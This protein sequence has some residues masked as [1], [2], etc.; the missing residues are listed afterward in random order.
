MSRIKVLLLTMCLAIC[1][2]VMAETS[3]FIVRVNTPTSNNKAA[4]VYGS[5]S[6]PQN[7]VNGSIIQFN[8]SYSAV[9][10][11]IKA[12]WKRVTLSD[13]TTQRDSIINEKDGKPDGFD[14]HK[15]EIQSI[16]EGNPLHHLKAR[17]VDN[18]YVKMWV[19]QEQVKE[20]NNTVTKNYLNIDYIGDLK[21][22][23]IT[24]DVYYQGQLMFTIPV[25]GKVGEEYPRIDNIYDPVNNEVSRIPFGM[26]VLNYPTEHVIRATRVAVETE[27]A[28]GA[29]GFYPEGTRYSQITDWYACTMGAAQ[30]VPI[31]E[32]AEY[33][34][35]LGIWVSPEAIPTVK[36]PGEEGFNQE[37]WNAHKAY[38]EN[39]AN[40]PLYFYNH[41]G[42][43]RFSDKMVLEESEYDVLTDM[44]DGYY[45]AM[46]GNP[47]AFR[48]MNKLA[49]PNKYLKWIR[50]SDTDGHFIWDSEGS[51]F[52]IMYN[53]SV[54]PG[55]YSWAGTFNYPDVANN[56]IPP[57]S[58]GCSVILAFESSEDGNF[59]YGLTIDPA[60]K[61]P[62]MVRHRFYNKNG[63]SI[64]PE[65]KEEDTAMSLLPNFRVYMAE[66]SNTSKELEYTV[67]M[68]VP[69]GR[70]P[71]ETMEVIYNEDQYENGRTITF[72]EE[73]LQSDFTA[74]EIEGYEPVVT[75]DNQDR[76]I[77]VTY[78]LAN[79]TASYPDYYYVRNKA[80]WPG[81]FIA[82]DDGGSFTTDPR[83]ASVITFVKA[84]T[85][86]GTANGKVYNAA[87]LFYILEATGGYWTKT[88]LEMDQEKAERFVL[89]DETGNAA[90]DVV[91]GKTYAI[92]TEED[93]LNASNQSL[94]WG[95]NPYDPAGCHLKNCPFTC[96]WEIKRWVNPKKVQ[97][98]IA[99]LNARGEQVAMPSATISWG[100]TT[101][102]HN[103][104]LYSIDE[105]ENYIPGLRIPILN[106]D[107]KTPSIY[108]Y[109][110][111]V[112]AGTLGV[113]YIQS[114]RVTRQ[115]IENKVKSKAFFGIVNQQTHGFFD[116]PDDDHGGF[117]QIAGAYNITGYS[118]AKERYLQ[119]PHIPMG[120]VAWEIDM[121]KYGESEYRFYLRNTSTG[122]YQAKDANSRGYVSTNRMPIVIDLDDDGNMRMEVDYNGTHFAGQDLSAETAPI[123]TMTEGEESKF[124]LISPPSSITKYNLVSDLTQG[125]ITI[126][127]TGE[128]FAAGN[129][130]LSAQPLTNLNAANFIRPK[131]IDGFNVQIVVDNDEA[132]NGA[133][134][135]VT[136][137]YTSDLDVS[138]QKY[139]IRGAKGLEEN[140]KE[141]AHWH[142]WGAEK[143]QYVDAAA[144][145][146]PSVHP[147]ALHNLFFSFEKTT[148]N[149]YR[150]CYDYKAGGKKYY[151]CGNVPRTNSDTPGN[152]Y[153]KEQGEEGFDINQAITVK[154]LHDKNGEYTWFV[155]PYNEGDVAW[156]LTWDNKPGTVW[157]DNKQFNDKS[158][159]IW[160]KAPWNTGVPFEIIPYT[161]KPV[162]VHITGDFYYPKATNSKG[163][164]VEV[165]LVRVGPYGVNSL[166]GDI[167]LKNG[168]QADIHMAI[169]KDDI[170]VR[171]LDGTHYT[172]DIE[173]NDIYV[174]YVNQGLTTQL[175]DIKQ[176]GT[177]Y[178][179]RTTKA[180]HPGDPSYG[181]YTNKNTFE[182]QYNDNRQ[183]YIDH[184]NKK[185]LWQVVEYDGRWYSWNDEEQS[186]IGSSETR[187]NMASFIADDNG[188][189]FEPTNMKSVAPLYTVQFA[190]YPANKTLTLDNSKPR[191]RLVLPNSDAIKAKGQAAAESGTD[192]KG[193]VADKYT[194]PNETYILIDKQVNGEG[195]GEGIHL[196]LPKDMGQTGTTARLQ[197]T[198]DG[199][200][201]QDLSTTDSETLFGATYTITRANYNYTVTFQESLANLKYRARY[202]LNGNK[203]AET[204]PDTYNKTWYFLPSANEWQALKDVYNSVGDEYSKEK[205]DLLND[206]INNYIR[207]ETEINWPDDKTPLFIKNR[208]TGFCM[209]YQ[210]PVDLSRLTKNPETI[211]NSVFY[212]NNSKELAPD[213]EGRHF[214]LYNV[215]G[216]VTD[217]YAYSAYQMGHP[218]WGGSMFG[219]YAATGGAFL[220]P[221]DDIVDFDYDPDAQI[222]AGELYHEHPYSPKMGG[223]MTADG[224]VFTPNKEGHF[225]L[226]S[227]IFEGTGLAEHAQTYGKRVVYSDEEVVDM[228][229]AYWVPVIPAQLDNHYNYE[230]QIVGAPDD[231][232]D[233]VNVKL[234]LTDTEAPHSV[235]DATIGGSFYL[236]SDLAVAGNFVASNIPMDGTTVIT[237]VIT[238]DNVSNPRKVVVTYNLPADYYAKRIKAQAEEARVMLA[239]DESDD[240]YDEDV[241][242]P[243]TY[244]YPSQTAR[245]ALKT[246][247]NQILAKPDADITADEYNN[248]LLPL[249]ERALEDYN[250]TTDVIVPQPGDVITIS[251]VMLCDGE[252]PTLG[253]L[254]RQGAAIETTE[255]A[256]LEEGETP[257]PNKI[258]APVE[259]NYYNW[260]VRQSETDGHVYL[261][262]AWAD[263]FYLTSSGVST[264]PTDWYISSGNF[265]GAL[266]L[267]FSGNTSAYVSTVTSKT[268]MT[269]TAHDWLYGATTTEKTH[270]Y[271]PTSGQGQS[272]DF[273]IMP[274]VSTIDGQKVPRKL[275]TIVVEGPERVKNA[276]IT[277]S[278][279]QHDGLQYLEGGG[280]VVTAR[281]PRTGTTSAELKK[282]VIPQEYADLE[283]TL[284]YDEA[285]QT[286][287]VTYTEKES[288]M[289]ARFL[290]ILQTIETRKY[291]LFDADNDGTNE[292]FDNRYIAAARAIIN[293]EGGATVEEMRQAMITFYRQA[294]KVPFYLINA[295]S[296]KAIETQGGNTLVGKANPDEYDQ[297]MYYKVFFNEIGN[298]DLDPLYY[299]VSVRNGN[300]ISATIAERILSTTNP[301]TSGL[302]NILNR[303]V[304][305]APNTPIPGYGQPGSPLQQ[306]TKVAGYVTLNC[307]NGAD[308]IG[309]WVSSTTANIDITG[310]YDATTDFQKWGMVLARNYRPLPSVY[311][312]YYINED[313][314][315]TSGIKD[316]PAHI[317]YV[318]REG[319]NYVVKCMGDPTNDVTYTWD[320]SLAHQ[321]Y[322]VE[323]KSNEYEKLLKFYRMAKELP[324][325]TDGKVGKYTDKNHLGT[326]LTNAVGALK[327]GTSTDCADKYEEMRQAIAALWLNM[328]KRGFYRIRSAKNGRYLS[329][330]GS[331]SDVA[332]PVATVLDDDKDK[333][334]ESIWYFDYTSYDDVN[335]TATTHLLNY[336][337]GQY[338][339]ACNTVCYPEY[340]TQRDLFTFS[341]QGTSNGGIVSAYAIRSGTNANQYLACGTG[342]TDV[343]RADNAE[344]VANSTDAAW[345]LEEVE[346]LPVKISDVGVATLCVP[347][348][349]T[350]PAGI[351]AGKENG[352][353]VADTDASTSKVAKLSLTEI[354]AGTKVP[355]ATPIILKGSEGTYLFPIGAAQANNETIVGGT[356]LKG[357]YESMPKTTTE[358]A[359]K[360]VYVL[361]YGKPGGTGEEVVGFFNDYIGNL[362]GFKVYLEYGTSSGAKAI[363][364]DWDNATGITG[365]TGNLP[366]TPTAIYSLDG[367]YLGTDLR[368]LPSGTYLIQGHKVVKK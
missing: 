317:Y 158:Q 358:T 55:T 169:D 270:L 53:Y 333:D 206:A 207:P 171:P 219:I 368:H 31:P 190:G 267:F 250:T 306:N 184:T 51:T 144:G 249:L 59:G 8:E 38:H 137:V 360:K 90:T 129:A 188:W 312:Y 350:I 363:I 163:E 294:E 36:H 119:P 288:S 118:P 11:K 256:K 3:E 143:S 62:K 2:M 110:L 175:K 127:T 338:L 262:N 229:N 54:L 91:E 56:I 52:G 212:F 240:Y 268:S 179:L 18:H 85:T 102:P 180:V 100:K 77:R 117:T 154:T 211:P 134:R 58:F 227:N 65:D 63:M 48:I 159:L 225:S 224:P 303:S 301:E 328:P 302:F 281:M 330:K 255:L 116:L 109:N 265:K 313:P 316:D 331:Q 130:F 45:W 167:S 274:A 214:Q 104:S 336:K 304:N 80:N 73:P 75:I 272:T 364:L 241:S 187:T 26:K 136:L 177:L 173:G 17:E 235:K 149:T 97:L 28:Y 310:A 297:N 14:V 245:D 182:G 86:S 230:I 111:N 293:K 204:V 275:L 325:T 21:P 329:M 68:V 150:I 30:M 193:D 37:A 61:T 361:M 295:G 216:D 7:Y 128:Y 344:Q 210:K 226:I 64:Q 43:L 99:Q 112:A 323:V 78:L 172:V 198:T 263:G 343:F 231:L 162:N 29:I 228:E 357:T 273:I 98:T 42:E 298:T 49:G 292:S 215:N 83:K 170:N 194:F 307:V 244:G 178:T 71:A 147:T 257:D 209:Y 35:E 367:R 67:E 251:G 309:S 40:T 199:T 345:Y 196:V 145:N 248:T 299:I 366:V 87:R 327:N 74:K 141:S 277:T 234:K 161:D 346:K 264:V 84:G 296:L 146:T 140:M 322:E 189:H 164:E 108:I 41:N 12:A 222:A 139:Y 220:D 60:R 340:R 19:N 266:S 79:T 122:L 160:L 27:Y 106:I 124:Y 148:D 319:V 278:Y 213:G 217:L 247:A 326:A 120:R 72:K 93:F 183:H 174:T 88:A 324:V 95:S 238:I 201:W 285:T 44:E 334:A 103:G 70:T 96:E 50:T 283:S 233:L 33:K 280:F 237:P 121:D 20:G 341:R 205:Y 311:R 165:G 365:P 142:Y 260:V 107:T 89:I 13:G 197:Y 362:N 24:Y 308:D 305:N 203:A 246:V 315:T 152:P 5:E 348:E 271:D 337:T 168:G 276:M 47:F 166:M 113:I 320:E 258:Y 176:D 16:V 218:E 191:F 4:V 252:T 254:H 156:T 22:V 76:K 153:W 57:F 151:L 354:N 291:P 290:N 321:W 32:D 318:E 195:Y 82:D 66:L 10:T 133:N 232:V 94:S 105:E 200:T 351:S 335:N 359:N 352:A 223:T 157:D 101:V 92:V 132:N 353:P 202:L 69:S 253:V 347:V 243:M 39:G 1:Q 239:Y 155:S 81:Y 131:Q 284:T 356:Y 355:A 6:Y 185:Y 125:G 259:H 282:V 349:V 242:D 287:T 115:T 138:G 339:Y 135:T 342:Y 181:Y 221:V 46:I 25:P 314:A 332:C 261:E 15:I 34:E 114:E 123:R 300:A 286:V 126:L 289:K 269:Q 23:T 9:D 208:Q 186:F 192:Y 279:A 236:R